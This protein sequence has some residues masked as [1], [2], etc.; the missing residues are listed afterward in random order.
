MTIFAVFGV[1]AIVIAAILKKEDAV[2]HYGL[3][4]SNM[5]K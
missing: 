5:K 3:E 2:K 4:E 1:I